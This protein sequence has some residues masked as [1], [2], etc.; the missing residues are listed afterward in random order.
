MAEKS[1]YIVIETGDHPVRNSIVYQITLPSGKYMYTH[2]HSE[3]AKRA[4]SMGL[5]MKSVIYYGACNSENI[6]ERAHGKFP[7]QIDKVSVVDFI[8]K[9]ATKKEC[10]EVFK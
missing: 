9:I 8:D 1:E 7:I 6:N 10:E 2:P 4:K 5:K 3:L